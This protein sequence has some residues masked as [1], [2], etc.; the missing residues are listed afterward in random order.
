M[1][2][3]QLSVLDGIVD[4]QTI[5]RFE[6]YL[7]NLSDNSA[8]NITV[9]IVSRN[10]GV[11]KELAQKILRVCLKEGI[12][13][14]EYGIRCPEC[15][16]MIKR[17]QKP[18]EDIQNISTCYRCEEEI[19]LDQSDIIAIF[20]FRGF[21]VPF[22]GGQRGIADEKSSGI[23]VA[24]EDSFLS[25]FNDIFA[26]TKRNNP[27]K[28]SIEC[29]RIVMDNV[30]TCKDKDPVASMSKDERAK[31][32]RLVHIKQFGYLI[33]LLLVLFAIGIITVVLVMIIYNAD[34]KIENLKMIL[35]I[36]EITVIAGS[37]FVLKSIINNLNTEKRIDKYILKKK[38][39]QD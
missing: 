22:V 13:S 19:Q 34:E 38:L 7:V 25:V 33:L 1:F 32:M 26:E 12:L 2:C 10:L 30:T 11:S 20:V 35:G 23:S 21:N 29:L 24:R 36:L 17:T 27:S 39:K 5:E 8:R 31:M 16:Q 37:I 6:N 28:S 15:G 14:L 4:S 18:L 9:S 3:S